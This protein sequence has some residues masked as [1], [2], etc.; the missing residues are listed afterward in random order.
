MYLN[1]TERCCAGMAASE[2]CAAALKLRHVYIF[3]SSAEF[4]REILRD[5][6][7]AVALKDSMLV[8]FLIPWTPSEDGEGFDQYILVEFDPRT[9]LE[10]HSVSSVTKVGREFVTP[11]SDMYLHN[12]RRKYCYT[13][14]PGG[15][16]PESFDDARTGF[17]KLAEFVYAMFSWIE[18]WDEF[19]ENNLS[20]AEQRSVLQTY[21]HY[22]H[23]LRKIEVIAARLLTYQWFPRVIRRLGVRW[24]IGA[25]RFVAF[26]SR[27]P[28]ECVRFLDAFK[29]LSLAK[30]V[31]LHFLVFDDVMRARAANKI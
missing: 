13:E 31:G 23:G 27:W 30:G 15:A 16:L 14:L 26:D 29:E 3:S 2:S 17:D 28:D 1:A 10:S 7:N 24:K 9:Y 4:G 5:R 22:E 20:A 18:N 8:S 25:E 21:L 11:G 19:L 6:S 12:G